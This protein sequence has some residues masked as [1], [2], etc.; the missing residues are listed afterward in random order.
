MV[1]VGS[2][3]LQDW[4]GR[5]VDTEVYLMRRQL[6]LLVALVALFSV[7]VAAPA[8][9]DKPTEVEYTLEPFVGWN[10]CTGAPTTV[11]INGI[12]YDHF[13]N[14]NFVSPGKRAGSNSDG[15]DL[16]HGRD[17]YMDN[18]NHF[19]INELVVF[20]N[21]EGLRYRIAVNWKRTYEGDVLVEKF[22]RVG[23]RCFGA[24]T[25]LPPW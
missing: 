14:N 16:V 18:G 24:P 20:E 17:H 23:F 11:T 7:V 13:H 4:C 5:A 21:D 15:Y 25:I 9:A 19:I 2:F 8:G 3:Q 22:D 6:S 12:A 10:P 1:R